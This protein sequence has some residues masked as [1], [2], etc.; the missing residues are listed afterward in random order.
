METAKDL[1]KVEKP[2]ISHKYHVSWAAKGCVWRLIDIQGE[3]A[4]LQTPKTKKRITAN[5]S[6][7]RH[8]RRNAYK[9]LDSIK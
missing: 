3:N 2:V 8:I 6:D 4:I 1:M 7:L 5:L 9:I